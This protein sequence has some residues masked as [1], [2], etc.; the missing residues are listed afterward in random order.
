[1]SSVRIE[2]DWQAKSACRGPFHSVFFP[3]T[4]GEGRL[5]KAR[6]EGRAKA[7]CSACSVR[8]D[9]LDYAVATHEP[10]GVWGGLNELERRPLWRD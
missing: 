7:I 8:K 3:P 1:M 4:M 10:H 5:D 2:I 6:R 9:C